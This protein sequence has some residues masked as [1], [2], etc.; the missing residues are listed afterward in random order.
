MFTRY[1]DV[2]AILRDYKRFSNMPSNR[3]VSKRR[4]DFA[5]P[6][7]DWTMLFLDPPEHTRLRALVNQAFTPRASTPWN[8]ISARSWENCST[9]WKTRR[10]ST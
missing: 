1:A 5:P 8:R 6:R 4:R 2:E 3:R 7:A 9:R 10:D